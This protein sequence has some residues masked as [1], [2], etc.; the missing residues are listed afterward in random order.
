LKVKSRLAFKV[1]GYDF[2]IA[3]ALDVAADRV[4]CFSIDGRVDLSVVDAV[5]FIVRSSVVAMW[6]STAVMGG[7]PMSGSSRE[8]GAREAVCSAGVISAESRDGALTT[9]KAKRRR[10]ISLGVSIYS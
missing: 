6:A 4:G 3:S 2:P 10:T 7:P 9:N 1:A 8:N 5:N